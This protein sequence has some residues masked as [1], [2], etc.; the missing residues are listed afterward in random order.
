LYA[1]AVGAKKPGRRT[2][3]TA[4]LEFFKSSV[5]TFSMTPVSRGDF[6]MRKSTAASLYMIASIRRQ[7]VKTH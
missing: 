3:F 6:L 7:F 4:K 5:D 1:A 2:E